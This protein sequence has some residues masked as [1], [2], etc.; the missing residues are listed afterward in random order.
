MAIF[1][2]FSTTK[3]KKLN[4]ILK[5]KH[6]GEISVTIVP[7]YLI[8]S[9]KFFCG[10]LLFWVP[11][12]LFPLIQNRQNSLLDPVTGLS[13]HATKC[14]SC[15]SSPCHRSYYTHT[16]TTRL[17]IC[18]SGV[19]EITEAP[20]IYFYY[21][22]HRAPGMEPLIFILEFCYILEVIGKMNNKRMPTHTVQTVF[23]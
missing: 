6:V 22:Q 11:Y 17:M 15:F 8:F 13:H 21:E 3:G 9:F 12:L 16:H 14:T 19:K 2:Q 7:S 10:I 5:Q 20:N 4:F 23:L 18:A 1:T